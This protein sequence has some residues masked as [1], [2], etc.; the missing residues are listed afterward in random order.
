MHSAIV[1]PT[2]V[3]VLLLIILLQTMPSLDSL[4]LAGASPSC[5]PYPTSHAFC[6]LQV[7]AVF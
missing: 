6:F 4:S 3:W 7:S 1:R 5:A 2:L